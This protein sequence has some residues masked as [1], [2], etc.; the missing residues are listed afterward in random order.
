MIFRSVAVA[1]AGIGLTDAQTCGTQVPVAPVATCGVSAPTAPSCGVECVSC[2]KKGPDPKIKIPDP[3]KGEVLE[4][5]RI[6]KKPMDVIIEKVVIKPET[7]QVPCHTKWG[8]FG[9]IGDCP[10]GTTW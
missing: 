10:K 2:S 1:L 3:I 8:K 4:I 5:I 7:K 6:E 9:P